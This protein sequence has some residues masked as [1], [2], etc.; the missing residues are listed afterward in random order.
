MKPARLTWYVVRGLKTAKER[1]AALARVTRATEKKKP[2]NT[3]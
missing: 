2:Q 3:P 1:G